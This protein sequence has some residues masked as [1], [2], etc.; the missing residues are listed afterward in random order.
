MTTAS[1]DIADLSG[2]GLAQPSLE[3]EA[4]REFPY[5][6][7]VLDQSGLLLSRNE[8]AARLIEAMGLPEKGLTCCALLGCRRPDTVLASA[9]VTELALSREDAL[10]EVRVDIATREGPS[11]MW[12]TA[13]AFGS[14]S[15]NVVLQLRPGTAQDRRRRTTPHWME[16]ARL[17][18]RTLGGTVVESAEGPIGG[19][20][21]DQRTGQ[22]LKYLLAERRRAVS[23]DEIGESVWAE[24]SY[25]VGGSVRYY[26]H[27]LRGKLEP[28]RGSREPSAFIIARAGTYRLNLDKIDVDADEFEAHVSAGLALIESDPLAAAEEIERGVAI[29]RGDFLSDVPYAEWATPERNRLRELACIGLRRLAEVRMEQRLIDSAAGWLERL[30]TLQPYDED[31]QRRLMELDIMRGRRSDAVRRYATLRARSRRTF[32]HDPGF[33]PADLA[34]PEH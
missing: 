33:T 29:Y 24:A 2:G 10:P 27:A 25:A 28:A 32:G 7:L 3:Q 11:A 15:R 21:L 31:V 17:R 1:G 22:L 4:F 34:R 23:V 14:G 20:W 13:A 12:V 5:A 19:A 26:I 6:L 30:A 8:Q 9:C 16:G 18:I